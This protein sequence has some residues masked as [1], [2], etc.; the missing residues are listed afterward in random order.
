MFKTY[1]NFTSIFVLFF[2]QED[3]RKF[4]IWLSGHVIFCTEIGRKHTYTIY[5]KKCLYV[6]N[7]KVVTVQTLEVCVWYSES[8]LGLMII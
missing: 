6:K 7:Y 3:G 2:A 1:S 8:I 4:Y 5:M